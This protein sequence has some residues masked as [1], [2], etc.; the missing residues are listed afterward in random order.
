MRVTVLKVRKV[1]YEGTAKEVLLPGADGEI[2]VLDFHQPFL[3]SLREGFIQIT[4][5]WNSVEKEKKK[6]TAQEIT[7]I[8]IR[9][10]IAKMLGNEMAV[11]IETS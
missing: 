11:M 10:G 5:E 2:C 1:V 9:Y 8:P 4:G 7:R 6:D 3:Y